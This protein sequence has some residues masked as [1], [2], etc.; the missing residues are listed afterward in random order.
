MNFNRQ[1]LSIEDLQE[2]AKKHNGKCLSTKYYNILT[3]YE[4]ECERGH[5]WMA[6]A[7]HVKYHDTWCPYCAG[8]APISLLRAKELAEK[9]DGECL[10]TYIEDRKDILL[11]KCREG[12]LF[13]RSYQDVVGGRWCYICSKYVNSIEKMQELAKQHNGKCLSDTFVNMQSPLLWQCEKGH[14]WE[15]LPY[16]IKNKKTWCPKC[17]KRGKKLKYT[18]ED[19]QKI[20]REKEGECLS[21]E[22]VKV[23]MKSTWKCKYGHVWQASLAS[24]KSGTW[25]PEC[26]KNRK[27][28]KNGNKSNDR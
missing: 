2:L 18:L 20:A 6:L 24:I 23:T 3:K 16:Y 14:I 13:K 15:T 21:K 8:K 11:W 27:E 4:W 26:W 12:H 22:V 17:T 7:S 28:I 1:K 19:M 9:K 25:C 5:H 10:S